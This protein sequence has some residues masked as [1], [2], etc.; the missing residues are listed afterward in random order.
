MR[1]LSKVLDSL[2]GICVG[3]LFRKYFVNYGNDM[4]E[5]ELRWYLVENVGDLGLILFIVVFMFVVG[6]EMIKDK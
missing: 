4:F 1:L 5:W 3:L 6:C 2:R